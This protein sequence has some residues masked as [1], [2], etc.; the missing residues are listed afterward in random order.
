M[1]CVPRGE[2]FCLL[3]LRDAL[4][5][6]GES[7]GGNSRAGRLPNK[8]QAGLEACMAPTERINFCHLPRLS[9]TIATQLQAHTGVGHSGGKQCLWCPRNDCCL[10]YKSQQA[11]WVVGNWIRRVVASKDQQLGVSWPRFLNLLSSFGMGAG[12][13]SCL[14]KASREGVEQEESTVTWWETTANP[15]AWKHSSWGPAC[16]WK[17]SQIIVSAHK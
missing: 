16:T 12:C 4:G 7:A 2:H 10:Q 6:P 17:L 13:A 15:E 5:L 8:K 9:P 11:Q 14:T 3:L 1:Q